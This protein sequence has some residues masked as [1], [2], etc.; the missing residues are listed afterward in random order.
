[1]KTTVKKPKTTTESKWKRL[2]KIKRAISIGG[3]WYDLTNPKKPIKI[4]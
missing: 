1:M 2:L 4:S 3:V